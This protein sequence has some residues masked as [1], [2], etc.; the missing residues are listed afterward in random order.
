MET[1]WL[2][3]APVCCKLVEL[4]W[5]GPVHPGGVHRSVAVPRCAVIRGIVMD[6]TAVG[7]LLITGPVPPPGP[8]GPLTWAGTEPT[9]VPAYWS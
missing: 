6:D 9:A 2:Y 3:I 4:P 8:C 1:L 7:G 5:G